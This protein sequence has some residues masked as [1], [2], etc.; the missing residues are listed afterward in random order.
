MEQMIKV[1]S[2]YKAMKL[3]ELFTI[4]HPE[5]G[6][7][8]LAELSGM[9]KSSVHNILVTFQACDI[10]EKNPATGKYRLG[11]K[12]LELNSVL[13]NNDDIRKIAKP[14]MDRVAEECRELILFAYPA[15][16]DVI[17]AESSCPRD[18]RLTR[19]ISGVKAEMHCT[20]IGKAMLAFMG[21]EAFQRVVEKGLKSYT[22]YT[23]TRADAL[24]S[25]L[26]ATRGRG[27][28]IDNMEHEYG[29]RCVGVPI[30]A[31]SGEVVAALSISGPSLRIMDE[32]LAFFARQL[33]D[34]AGEITNTL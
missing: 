32:K 11:K 18:M 20:S 17:Y 29:I 30:H 16:T 10:V 25:D 23:L 1:K 26:E 34:A 14:I 6:V 8:E 22:P 4:H 13:A 31:K 33:R 5:R 9:L 2:L 24:A 15:G 21:A 3:L 12:I 28:A 27:Y 19:S 7:K